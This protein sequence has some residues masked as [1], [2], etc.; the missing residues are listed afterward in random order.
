MRRLV[1]AALLAVAGVAAFYGLRSA[2][3]AMLFPAPPLPAAAPQLGDGV[4]NAF[5]DTADGRVEAF[6]LP[7]VSAGATPGPLLV[8]A[9]GNGELVDFWL[10]EFDALRANGLSILLVEYPGYGRS[11]GTPSEPSIRRAMVA[12]Y[13]WALAHARIDAQ[14]VIGHGRSLG[15]GALCALGRERALAALVLESTF[16][17][18]DEVARELFGVPRFL[19]SNT[20]D[21]LGFVGAYGSPVLLLHGE[22]DASIPV[23]HA[24]RLARALPAA[25]L[26]L[27]PCGH[28]DCPRPWDRI[29]AFLRRHDLL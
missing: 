12:G 17:R 2:E 25:Q 3:T 28:N 4:V 21:N 20:F 18:V 26:E 13:D 6:L 8:Y 10:G 11:T 22:Q 29:L 5:L 16:T 24:Q 9:H 23:A 1:I 27:L 19:V 15:G 14:R 7:G